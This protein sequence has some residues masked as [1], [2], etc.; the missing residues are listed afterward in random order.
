MPTEDALDAAPC[1]LPAYLIAL[2]P[3]VRPTR[4]AL[5]GATTDLGR[6][7]DPEAG[8]VAVP[9]QGVSR[10]HAQV[11]REGGR[12]VVRDAGST[13]GT[14]VNGEWVHAPRRLRH[15]DRIALGGAR[16]HLRF[17]APG[18]SPTGP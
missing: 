15:G 7:V 16:P 3:A 8:G 1:G 14:F 18:R 4:L 2:T 6:D 11:A 5:L 10:R 17:V 12:Y 9:D 13:N